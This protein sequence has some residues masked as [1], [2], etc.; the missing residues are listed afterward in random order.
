MA[1]E[2]RKVAIIGGGEMG[3]G[4]GQLVAQ[5]GFPVVVKEVSDD[6]AKA[7]REAVFSQLDKVLRS[8][9]IERSE[10]EGAKARFSV[11][12][13]YD[14]IRDA[15]L[16]IEAVFEDMKVKKSV[17]KE[18]DPLFPEH[19]IFATNSSSLSITELASV[20]KRPDRFIGMHFFNPAPSPRS[21][22]V[23][24]VRGDQTSDETH[25]VAERFVK[26]DLQKTPITVKGCPGYLVNRLLLPYLNEAAHLLTE[27]TL[28]VKQIDARATAFG[29]PMG[30]F[31]LLDYVGNDIAANVAEIL[32]KGYGERAKPVPILRRMVELGRIGKKTKAGFYI[33]DSSLR[34][35]DIQ[36]IIDQEYPNRQELNI[37]IGFK[38]MMAGF[39][40]E[41][42]LCLQEGIASPDIIDKGTV[43]GIGFPMALEGPLHDTQDRYGF[44]NLLADLRRFE[45]EYGMRFKP[46]EILEELVAGNKKIFEKIEEEEW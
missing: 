43:L 36:V 20:T 40:N 13:S 39:R 34:L 42:L 21:A 33:A 14:D 9:A 2:I 27:T 1:R 28:A 15:D 18:I 7:C 17:F 35:E 19:V 4:I 32:Y 41:A 24:L 5:K 10:A 22:L 23:E 44:A 6:R 16:V 3:R 31:A 37:E 26:V 38:R 45:K 12:G 29:L 25:G 11:T 46:A 8:R 30:P